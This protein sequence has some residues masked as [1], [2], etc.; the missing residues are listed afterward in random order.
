[1]TG[2]DSAAASGGLVGGERAQG[3]VT[4]ADLAAAVKSVWTR[5]WSGRPGP[6]PRSEAVA[7]AIYPLMQQ[8]ALW[9]AQTFT[10]VP[11]PVPVASVGEGEAVAALG[12]LLA[13][14]D[15]YDA[16]HQ[17]VRDYEAT[18]EWR[19]TEDD[20]PSDDYEDVEWWNRRA[21]AVLTSD[22]LTRLL[23][24]ARRNAVDEIRAA[25]EELPTTRTKGELS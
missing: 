22:W 23:A 12:E 7:R 15:D 21:R 6:A 17:R 5:T 11:A 10:T 25:V 24:D 1:M 20:Y 13:L 3:E 8:H 16:C 14:V 19:R 9:F 2:P 4:L 18:P